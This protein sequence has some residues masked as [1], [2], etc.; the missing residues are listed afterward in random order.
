MTQL[1]RLA[2]AGLIC[3]SGIA[4]AQPATL[5]TD[6]ASVART[7]AKPALAVGASFD[8]KGRLWLARVDNR[9][10]VVSRSD[11]G[12]AHFT[13]GVIVPSGDENIAADGENRPK[14]AVAEDGT[15][16]LSWTQLLPQAYSGNVRFARSTDGG[17]TFSSPVTLNDDGR[18]ASHRFDSLA[19]DG[20]GH[21]VVMWLD[22]RDRDAARARGE[23][24]AGVSLYAAE[25]ADG[26][27]RFMANRRITEHV[28]ECCRTGVVWTRDGAVGFWRNL[29]GANTRDFA[30]GWLARGTTRRA[31]DDAWKIDACP[32]H[33]GAIAA[34]ADG[35]VHVVWFTQG[36]ARQGLFYRHVRGEAMTAPLA[37]GDASAQAGHPSV[38][39]AGDFVLITWREFDGSSYA[40]MAKLSRDGGARWSAPQKLATTAG[41]AD[42][43]V[44]L[45]HDGR[46]TV[47]WNTAREGL[48]VVGA[49]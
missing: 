3:W 29:Y 21:V 41:A 44:P 47:V 40:A 38:A 14:I 37:F 9:R 31:T 25:S 46:A 35:G 48:R 8:R 19:T 34:A 13:Q 20:A 45:I 10:L 26:G 15:V 36:S 28:C 16:L 43:P 42:Y 1:E 17:Q 7:R 6:P 30:L 39:A 18:V 2:I 24:F 12:G 27:A 33:G 11:D 32:H 22:A 49:E 23:A 4:W 5:V